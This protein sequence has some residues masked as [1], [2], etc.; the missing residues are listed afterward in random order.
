MGNMHS[1]L[2]EGQYPHSIVGT[3]GELAS[4]LREFNRTGFVAIDNDFTKNLAI[5]LANETNLQDEHIKR[6]ARNDKELKYSAGISQLGPK[7]KQ[8]LEGNELLGTLSLLTGDSHCLT[9]DMSCITVYQCGDQLGP[10]KDQPPEKC[11]VTCILYLDCES[12]NPDSPLSGLRLNV[13]GRC[14]ASINHA[15]LATILTKAG[16]LAIGRG[17]QVWHERPLL[18][19]G[20]S[21]IAMTVCFGVA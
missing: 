20:E 9:E 11:D 17:S 12:P 8:W 4:V 2:F 21:V 19:T 6:A 15:P 16:R 3:R 18:K 14:R 10:H 13:F 5:V 1:V 7:A